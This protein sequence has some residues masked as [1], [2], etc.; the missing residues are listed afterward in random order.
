M[1]YYEYECDEC[2]KRK[3][4]FQRM[5]DRPLT[6]CDQCGGLLHKVISLSA[7]HLKGKGWYATDYG[8]KETK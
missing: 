8:K 1:P 5:S 6:K 7:F 2:G 4:V 3:E